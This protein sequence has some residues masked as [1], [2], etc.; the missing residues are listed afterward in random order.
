[1]NS[2]AKG[3]SSKL[4]AGGIRAGGESLALDGSVVGDIGR[5]M[6]AFADVAF[7]FV[8]TRLRLL[9]F[10]WVVSGEKPVR[11]RLLVQTSRD[12]HL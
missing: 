5:V 1:M 12:W 6:I 4:I 3:D 7:L 2:L 11:S 8:P 10:G 9:R